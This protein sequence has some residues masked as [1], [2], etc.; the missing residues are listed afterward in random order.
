MT[1]DPNTLAEAAK[2]FRCLPVKE[3]KKMQV[4]A[5]CVAAGGYVPNVPGFLIQ[6]DNQ[7]YILLDDGGRIKLS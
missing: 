1:C 3:L 6:D 4:L 7:G 5:L 2:C